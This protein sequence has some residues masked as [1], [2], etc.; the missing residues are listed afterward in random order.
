[1]IKSLYYSTR[2]AADFSKRFKAFEFVKWRESEG[3]VFDSY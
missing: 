2:G 3:I 1:M